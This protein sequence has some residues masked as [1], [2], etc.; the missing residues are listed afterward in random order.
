MRIFGHNCRFGIY[1]GNTGETRMYD[2][3]NVANKLI[4]R[5]IKDDNPLTPLQI[6]KLT[7]FCHGWTLGFYGEP[8]IIQNVE[9]WRNGPVIG[10]VYRALSNYGRDPVGELI[11]N[12]KMEPFT[13][14]AQSVIDLVYVNYGNKS[15]AQLWKWTHEDGTPWHQV[16]DEDADRRWNEHHERTFI[17]DKLI[18]SYF[19]GIIKDVSSKR[20]SSH[21]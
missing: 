18:G 4:D 3:R 9:A 13:F 19:S 10:D 15:G 11:P 2:A 12:V 17:D 14:R 21:E 1:N 16:W 20:L 5:S 7:Y 6:I 8:L